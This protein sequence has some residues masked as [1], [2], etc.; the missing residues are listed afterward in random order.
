MNNSLLYNQEL[1]KMAKESLSQKLSQCQLD[2]T[3]LE[4]AWLMDL[5]QTAK[6]ISQGCTLSFKINVDDYLKHCT[7]T[8]RNIMYF[9]HDM[10][11]FIKIFCWEHHLN[12]VKIINPQKQYINIKQLFWCDNELID[13]E[14]NAPKENGFWQITFGIQIMP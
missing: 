5:K 10:E 9:E 6:T 1:I 4:N 8:Y 13:L 7:K 3:K 11:T 14:K 2:T 12:L